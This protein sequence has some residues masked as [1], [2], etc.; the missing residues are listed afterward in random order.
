M[1]GWLIVRGELGLGKLDK[2]ARKRFR[3][4]LQLT[5]NLLHD[6]LC[7]IVAAGI[8]V[9]RPIG[10]AG[11]AVITVTQECPAP[12]PGSASTSTSFRFVGA[13]PS[14]R[15]NWAARWTVSGLTTLSE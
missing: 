12:F 1:L 11:Y 13:M 7:L 10:F 3:S 9:W 4:G 15:Y 6:S 8:Y 14:F 5:I 2:S